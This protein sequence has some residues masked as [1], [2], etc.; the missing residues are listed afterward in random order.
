[1]VEIV[2]KAQPRILRSILISFVLSYSVSLIIGGL[3]YSGLS[4]LVL[5]GLAIPIILLAI[6]L[7]V[8]DFRVRTGMGVL[9][10]FD[11][12]VRVVVR[13]RTLFRVSTKQLQIEFGAYVHGGGSGTG[14]PGRYTKNGPAIRLSSPLSKRKLTAVTTWQSLE[15]G[16]SKMSRDRPPWTEHSFDVRLGDI[17][18]EGQQWER[19]VKALPI[20][21]VEDS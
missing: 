2:I 3:Y 15:S 5:G 21:W 17:W 16:D 20:R 9:S 7:F 13:G 10:V 14:S 8:H 4:S 11:D 12:E 6:F 18:L 19:L 1:M